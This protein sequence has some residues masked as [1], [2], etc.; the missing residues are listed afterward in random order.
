MGY[1]NLR[2]FQ[3]ILNRKDFNYI[4]D[5]EKIKEVEEII[6]YRISNPDGRELSYIKLLKEFLENLTSFYDSIS[7]R[8]I[9]D[10]KKGYLL[11]IEE[12]QRCIKIF[13]EPEFKRK[14]ISRGYCKKFNKILLYGLYKL[15]DGI[16]AAFDSDIISSTKIS[17]KQF[18]RYILDKVEG[19]GKKFLFNKTG[20]HAF[21]NK[22]S[23]VNMQELIVTSRLLDRPSGNQ[24]RTHNGWR[25]LGLG[26]APVRIL[27][28]HRGF[29]KD[30]IYFLYRLNE[31]NEYEAQLRTSPDKLVFSAA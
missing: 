10:I 9:P 2:N 3:T 30:R 12:L 15:L 20:R 16:R 25:D 21:V 7:G 6:L 28:E 24:V 13:T 5:H 29:R 22:I 8:N 18:I 26:H 19:L 14:S 1:K 31:H 27:S 17:R 4:S 23:A 11:V